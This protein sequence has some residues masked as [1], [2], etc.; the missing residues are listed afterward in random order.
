MDKDS[1]GI[2]AL[3]ARNI[4]S[5]PKPIKPKLPVTSVPKVWI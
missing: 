2:D 5:V 1:N 3:I 4:V